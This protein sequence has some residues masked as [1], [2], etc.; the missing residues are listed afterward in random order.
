MDDFEGIFHPDVNLCVMCVHSWLE[1]ASLSASA[2][3]KL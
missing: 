1:Q 3:T 2:E